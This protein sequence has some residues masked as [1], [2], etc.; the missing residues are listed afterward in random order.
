M[1]VKGT[2]QLDS[3][4]IFYFHPDVT[5]AFYPSNNFHC[6]SSWVLNMWCFGKI[7]TS[8]TLILCW[9]STPLTCI[10]GTGTRSA[11]TS[12]KKSLL[13]ANISDYW[14]RLVLGRTVLQIQDWKASS[15]Q[16]I[17]VHDFSSYSGKKKDYSFI[18]FFVVK[19]NY[20]K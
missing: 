14:Y 1:Y 12:A 18:L 2:K 19:C 5:Q 9:L 13:C 20:S 7:I 11:L 4:N 15:L 6:I 10:L 8:N 3:E 16:C 17:V